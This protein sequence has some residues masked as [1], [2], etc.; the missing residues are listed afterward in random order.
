MMKKYYV[1]A[2]IVLSI[3]LF[4]PTVNNF[5]WGDDWYHLRVSQIT[6]PLEFINFFSFSHTLQSTPFYR[7]ISTQL[8]FFLSYRLFGLNAFPYYLILI[9]AF[10]LSLYLLY[11]LAQKLANNKNTAL[12]SVFFYGISATNFPRLYYLS[13]FQEILMVIFVIASMLK[14]LTNSFKGYILSLLFFI[15]ALGS[16]ETAIVLPFILAVFGLWQK[17]NSKRRLMPFFLIVL[18]YLLVRLLNWNVTGKDSYDFDFSPVKYVNTL[19]WYTLWSLGVPE[20]LVDYVGSG[21]QVLDRFYQDFPRWSYILLM[22]TFSTVT[23]VLSLVISRWRSI[24]RELLFYISFFLVGLSPV[25]FL[26][27]HKFAYE[28]ALPLVGFSLI[29]AFLVSRSRLLTIVNV[30][31]LSSFVILN[32][33]TNWLDYQQHQSITRSRIAKKIVTTFSQN[34]PNPPSNYYFEFV[35]DTPDFGTDWGSSKQISQA[36]SGSN[37]FKVLYRDRTYEVYFEDLP[38]DRPQRKNKISISTA[39]FLK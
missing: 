8:F 14:Y 25:S 22:L 38:G 37:L 7:P 11:C 33:A 24:N 12:L 39:D 9:S 27:W 10:A 2:I 29:L 18:I 34:Y 31:F 23:A 15:L 26:P 20:L 6:N 36:I 5:F 16:K 3:T 4:L 35:N 30:L 1:F 32:L 19:S 13:N 28:L 17:K 21:F